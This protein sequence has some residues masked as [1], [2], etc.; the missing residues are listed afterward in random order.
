MFVI[1]G[2]KELPIL[3]NKVELEVFYSAVYFNFF[4]LYS[5]KY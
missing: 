5:A 1:K 2:Y 3:L 4:L